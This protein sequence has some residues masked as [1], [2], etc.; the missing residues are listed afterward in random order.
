MVSALKLDEAATLI[1][2]FLAKIVDVSNLQNQHVYV[3]VGFAN[4]TKMAL[5]H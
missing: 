1:L 3:L 4:F 2:A 5:M